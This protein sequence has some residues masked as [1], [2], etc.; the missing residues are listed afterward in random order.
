MD[1]INPLG[2]HQLAREFFLQ[3]YEKHFQGTII[4][5][6]SEGIVLDFSIV[7]TD[8]PP[9]S[10]NV[11]GILSSGQKCTLV[12]KFDPEGLGIRISRGLGTEIRKALLSAAGDGGFHEP[13]DARESDHL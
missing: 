12:G 3:D 8:S 6:P 4:A 13:G 10:E 11:Y 1:S 2:K 5:S 9:G 7:G